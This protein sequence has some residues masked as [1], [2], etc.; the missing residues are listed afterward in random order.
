MEVHITIKRQKA[1]W[2]MQKRWPN[3]YLSII[4]SSLNWVFVSSQNLYVKILMP[5]IMVLGCEPN[6]S[7]VGPLRG[8]FG[9]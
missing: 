2:V 5:N 4:L 1:D 9:G 6:T 7:K 3:L 8:A